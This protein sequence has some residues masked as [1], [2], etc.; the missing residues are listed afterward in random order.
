MHAFEKLQDEKDELKRQE[1][2]LA[3]WKSFILGLRIRQRVQ[4]T[5][6]ERVVQVP[7]GETSQVR[8]FIQLDLD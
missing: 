4:A 5:Y 1:R 8:P 2:C 7:G 6:T 3:R